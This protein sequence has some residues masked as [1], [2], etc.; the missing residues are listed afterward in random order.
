MP[1]HPIAFSLPSPVPSLPTTPRPDPSPL[2]QSISNTLSSTDYD[3]VSLPLTNSLWQD[4]WERLCL[5]PVD[6][7][8]ELT[9]E[10]SEAKDREREK[11]D[12][13]A[14]IWRR[15]GGLKRDE[16]NVSRLEESQAVITTAAEW[17]ELDSPDE[18]IRFDS[19]IA[20]RSEMAQALYLSLPVLIIP[21][22]SLINR[23]YLPSY[24]RA[25]SNLL[26]MGGP[27]A[28]TQISIR[29]PISD[30]VELITQGPAPSHS[31]TQILLQ[32]QQ[33]QQQG[34]NSAGGGNKH[35]RMSSLSTRPT[36]MH[37]AQLQQMINQQPSNPQNLRIAS[38]ASSTMSTRSS[39]AVTGDP[40]S[41][42][43]MWDCIRTLCNYHPR[44]SVTLDLSNPLPPSVGALARWTA[45]PV[46]YIWVPAGSFI[47]NAKGYPVLSKACQAFLRG[48]SKQN[49]TYVLHGTTTQKHT[50]GGPNA[51][52]QY[53]RHITSAPAPANG[54]PPSADEFTSG[55]ADYLQAPLQPLM[56]DLGSATYDIFER[57]PVKYRQYEEAITLALSD[58]PADKT[59]VVTVV[60]AGRGPLV[61]CTLRA[62]TR[63]NRRAN[64][65]AVEKNAN[66]F[67][68]LQER[69]AIEWGDQ[70]EIF[71]GDMRNVDVPEKCDIM[72]SEL[73]GSF[74][75]N[76]LSPECLDG[77]MRFMKP[78]G[79]SIPTSY[80]AHVAPISSSK[81]FHDVHQPSRPA[82]ATETP[83]VVMMSQ[84]NL[85]SGDGGG[86]SGR[87]GE[88]VQ[89]CWQF[90]HPRRDLILDA[91]GAPLTNTH[92]TRSSRHVFHIP[93]AATLH[94]LAG[95]FEAHL[96]SNVGLSI[97]P[98]NAHRVSPDM[99]SWFPLY[100]PLKEALYLPSGSELE[101]NLWRLCDSRGRKIWYE[102]SV[103]SYLSVSQ[104][105]PSSAG[106]LTPNGSRHV[107]TSGN[108][109][110][111]QPSPLMDAPFSPGFSSNGSHALSQQNG[112]MG[113]L[114]RIKIG[115]TSL[116]NP[117]GTH[118]WVGL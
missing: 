76:E 89:Q 102:W 80:T 74:G 84:V 86:V 88:K 83:Y 15:D 21:A 101:V 108:G 54:L 58:L 41:T 96:Y 61:A 7:E 49:P 8:E 14:D 5:R 2:Q 82:G 113:E 71:F 10:Q 66:A 12:L 51:Y 46:K 110:G 4:R 90:E 97:H 32:Q 13:E 93:H 62:L 65:Y 31:Q 28:F 30:P 24:A 36:S 16:V 11:V 118:S 39:A 79:I 34:A 57:D 53:V 25:I 92:N 69:K 91:S 37:Q 104:H 52:L 81:L 40:S 43:E 94:G 20:L 6:E 95:Y 116:H 35:K 60:G 19:E 1:R 111:G 103:E 48:M 9:P 112:P 67:I 77:A 18:G 63:S 17:L 38:G 42:W 23:A 73:L 75:D 22:P 64:V 87:C 33:Q 105:I 98:D 85:I 99:F 78:T 109:L 45:E 72:V 50:A 3:L 29:I 115:Q 70:V 100:F 55:Y 117:A 47:P 106:S 114:N 27:S 107:S 26:Q 68:T 59:H 44:L 56:D